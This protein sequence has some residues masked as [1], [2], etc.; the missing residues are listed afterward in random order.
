MNGKRTERCP[1]CGRFIVF[2]DATCTV[3]HDKPECAVF[4]AIAKAA[5]LKPRVEKWAEL[6]RPD[7]TL[8]QDGDGPVRV[9]G[10]GNA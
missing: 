6:V 5:G 8:V 2:E 7:G 9:K 1:G 4:L 10:T 3:R